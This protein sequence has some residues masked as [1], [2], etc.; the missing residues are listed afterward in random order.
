MGSISCQNVF[1]CQINEAGRR[2]EYQTIRLSTR[3]NIELL[4]LGLEYGMILHSVMEDVIQIIN[5]ANA[6]LLEVRVGCSVIT[7]IYLNCQQNIDQQGPLR[8]EGLHLLHWSRLSSYCHLICGLV[9]KKLYV[10]N[11]PV[12]VQALAG[13]LLRIETYGPP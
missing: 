2:P 4:V 8:S 9:I 10:P 11:P 13:P 1:S 5:I 12:L 3:R 6:S 7:K